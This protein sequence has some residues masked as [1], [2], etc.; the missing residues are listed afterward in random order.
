MTDPTPPEPAP[1]APPATSPVPESSSGPRPGE[2]VRE[3]VAVIIFSISLGLAVDASIHDVEQRAANVRAGYVYVISNVGA[4]GPGMVK[5]G[6]TRRL[7]PQDRVRELGDASVP[8]LFDTHALVFSED[9][10]GLE[11]QLH[12]ALEDRR[13]NRVNLRREFFHATPAEV[14]ALLG[15]FKGAELSF[16]EEPEAVEWHQSVNLAN[17]APR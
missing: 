17:A 9:A 16:V 6:M 4:F 7:D 8:F 3:P 14:R 2:T 12:R 5:V 13:V 15:Q 10:V 11:Q 1:S